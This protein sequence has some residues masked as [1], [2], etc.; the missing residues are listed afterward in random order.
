M[1]WY[2]LFYLLGVA[3]KVEGVALGLSIF[4]TAVT[5][6][7]LIVWLIANADYD[8][9]LIFTNPQAGN[10]TKLTDGQVAVMKKSNKFRKW[11]GGFIFAM[12][13]FW[14]LYMLIPNKRDIILIA[15]GGGAMTFLSQDSTAKQIPANITKF[16]NTTLTTEIAKLDKETREE[17]GA[18]TPKER[19]IDK[20]KEMTK[21][22]LIEYLR[23]DTTLVK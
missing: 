15:A 4:T 10:N 9:F 20:A 6:I 2:G 7:M 13:F 3:D 23:T 18:V 8:E 17:L 5:V 11:W 16:L 21:E 1:N 14:T 19:L 12:C 22:E